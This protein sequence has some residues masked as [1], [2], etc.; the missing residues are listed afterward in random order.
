MSGTRSTVASPSRPKPLSGTRDLGR[1]Q[2]VRSGLPGDFCSGRPA[3]SRMNQTS[4]IRRNKDVPRVERAP[5]GRTRRGSEEGV[6]LTL[7]GK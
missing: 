3:P 6:L 7:I 4:P 1:I 5:F 2:Q